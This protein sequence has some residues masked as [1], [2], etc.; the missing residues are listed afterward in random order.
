MIL[1]QGDPLESDLT[2]VLAR[3]RHWAERY[4]DDSSPVQVTEV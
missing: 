4:Y 3:I 1:Q 2:T